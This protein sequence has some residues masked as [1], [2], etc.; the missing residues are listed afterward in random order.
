MRIAAGSRVLRSIFLLEYTPG[1]KFDHFWR[2]ASCRRVIWEPASQKDRKNSPAEWMANYAPR[3][4]RYESRHQRYSVRRRGKGY[5]PAKFPPHF[6]HLRYST[7]AYYFMVVQIP[8]LGGYDLPVA[9]VAGTLF[10]RAS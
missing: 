7:S 1:S 6:C 9:V 3:K 8:L 5:A 10:A 2:Q 4:A